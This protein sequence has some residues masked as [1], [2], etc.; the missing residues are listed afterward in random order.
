MKVVDVQHDGSTALLPMNGGEDEGGFAFR[1][2]RHGKALPIGKDG[3]KSL[4]ELT[5]LPDGLREKLTQKLYGDVNVALLAKKGHYSI[6]TQGGVVQNFLRTKPEFAAPVAKVLKAIEKAIPDVDFARVMT[7]PNHVVDL[8]VIGAEEKPV[9]AGD[10][11]RAGALVKFSPIGVAKPKVQS[12]VQVLRCTNGAISNDII[13]EFTGDDG[14]DMWNFFRRSVRAASRSI[15]NIIGQ[16]QNLI[17]EAL[18]PQDR[19][20]MLAALIKQARL[21]GMD[22]EA[23]EQKALEEPPRTAYDLM[24]IMTWASSHVIRDP[25]VVHRVRNT[26]AEFAHQTTHARICPVCRRGQ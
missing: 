5:G 13:R 24:Q 25:A 3:L 7:Y 9:Q 20:M 6:I 2:Y 23:I 18:T 12:Y 21:T 4:S 11:V 17:H 22:K 19:A 8:E 1:P 15:D 10:L 26:A 14:G 16:W